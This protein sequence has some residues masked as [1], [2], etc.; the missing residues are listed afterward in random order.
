MFHATLS[1]TEQ[2]CVSYENCVCVHALFPAAL[3][4]MSQQKTEQSAT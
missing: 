3:P 1:D 4:L 2:T